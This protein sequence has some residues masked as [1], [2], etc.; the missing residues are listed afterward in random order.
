MCAKAKT[1]L[2]QYN[3]CPG[4]PYAPVSTPL[5]QTA[6]F[7]QPAAAELGPYDYTRS[8]N[9]TRAVLEK[10]LADLEGAAAGTAAGA[11]AGVAPTAA[12]VSAFAFCSGMAAI[13]AVTRLVNA[14]ERIVA[15]DD[16]YGGTYRL[17]GRLAEDRG[18]EVVYVDTTDPGGVDAAL[19]SRTRLVLLESP[20][21]PLLKVSDIES[22][23]ALAHSH[24][25]PLAVDNSL[26]SPY[27]QRPLELGA[28]I[29]VE[30]ATKALSGHSDLTAGVVATRD[31]D[32]ADRLR[33]IQNSEGAGLAPFESWLLL[34]SA[35][36]L[37][38]RLEAQQ[39][40]A[41]R[42]AEYLCGCPMIRRVYYPGLEDHPGFD[43]HGRQAGGPGVLMSFTTGSDELSEQMVNA[44]RLFKIAVSFGSVTSVI[45]Q[46]ARLS[47][48]SVPAEIRAKRPLPE[49]LV[50]LSVG[51]EDGDDLV[52]DLAQAIKA[53]TAPAWS[54]ILAA[55]QP[56]VPRP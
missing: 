49:G 19:D 6:T 39:L 23:A 21:N 42:V 2:I 3:A 30:S 46:P 50:R 25:V 41:R 9:P 15:G 5:Y 22:I 37:A 4:D 31:P 47:H 8:G 40:N 48:A 35:K 14:G 38:V 34:R 29:V 44:T 12:P 11:A 27:L 20:T 26:M 54:P 1:R 43:L 56:R 51:L 16:L 55:S 13:T 52:E 24:G 17:L 33:W 32:V 53:A 36:T 28:D 7:A 45:S 10:L 18:I